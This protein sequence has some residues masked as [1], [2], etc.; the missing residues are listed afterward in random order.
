[1]NWE[2]DSF[3]GDSLVAMV[4]DPKQPWLFYGVHTNNQVIVCVAVKVHPAAIVIIVM[5]HDGALDLDGPLGQALPADVQDFHQGVSARG[6]HLV[7]MK[8]TNIATTV[9]CSVQK[10]NKFLTWDCVHLLWEYKAN[11]KKPFFGNKFVVDTLQK[12][13]QHQAVPVNLEAAKG[14]TVLDQEF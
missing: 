13:P 7:E 10:L 4:G 1:M 14:G 2:M 8:K 6:L 9:L 11:L 12:D 5:L 3:Q